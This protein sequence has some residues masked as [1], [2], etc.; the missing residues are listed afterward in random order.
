MRPEAVQGLRDAQTEMNRV[1]YDLLTKITEITN[2][3]SNFEDGNL[4]E[5]AH[6][7][8]FDFCMSK[9]LDMQRPES[10]A[11]LQFT[12]QGAPAIVPQDKIDDWFHKITFQRDGKERVTR[13][14][15]INI[16]RLLALQ[17]DPTNSNIFGSMYTIV[18]SNLRKNPNGEYYTPGD[19]VIIR[20]GTIDNNYDYQDFERNLQQIPN[21]RS[22]NLPENPYIFSSEPVVAPEIGYNNPSKYDQG[23]KV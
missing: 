16:G 21:T 11:K 5:V 9:I 4:T 14:R 19:Y 2:N 13:L 3:P 20:I 18:N 23:A 12:I 7:E 8:F 22:S 10:K 17:N 15:K 6:Q 1:K